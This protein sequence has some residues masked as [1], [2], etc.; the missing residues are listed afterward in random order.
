MA[1]YKK[2]KGFAVQT[3]SSDTAA[4]GVS[5]GAWASGGALN[6]ARGWGGRSGAGTQTAAQAAAGYNPAKSAN[7]E[8][9]N[10]SSWTET[11]DVNTARSS[12]SHG[13]IQTSSMVVGG[14]LAPGNS[15][16]TETWNGSAWTEVNN[17]NTARR[18][19]GMSTAGNSTSSIYFAGYSTTYVGIAESWNGSSWTEVGD[20]NTPRSSL[21]STDKSS[22]AA[23]GIAGYRGPP[24]ADR[25][26]FVEEWNGS[27][28]T[29]I[30]DVNQERMDLG[31]GGS[32]T[33]CI[34]FGGTDTT[35]LAVTESWDGSSWTE[36]AD[37]ATAR[38]EVGGTGS[39]TAGLV[40]GGTTPPYTSATEEF[41]ATTDFTKQNLGQVYFNST[42][43]TFKTTQSD[44]SGGTWASGGT[45]NSARTNISGMFAGNKT[46]A[47][48]YGGREAPPAKVAYTESYDG[49]SWTE[50]ND[51]N[52]ARHFAGGAGTQTA[53]LCIGNST[54]PQTVVE[55]WNGSSW[56]EITEINT[57]RG[58]WTCAGT[59]TDAIAANG[60]TNTMVN[61]NELWNGSTWT[62]SGNTNSTADGRSS[63]GNTSAALQAGGYITTSPPTNTTNTELWNGSSW[64]EVNN[65]NQAERAAQGGG[66]STQALACG[67]NADIPPFPAGLQTPVSSTEFWNGTSWTEINDMSTTRTE[68]GG[69]GN[70]TNNMVAGG[71]V[72]NAASYTGTS[73]EWTAALTNK[74]ITVS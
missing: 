56:T 6:N 8:N 51:L 1:E 23:L 47:L 21:T 64:T 53:A 11:T 34:I 67:G 71:Q 43:N 63:A 40:F 20:L 18:Q 50:V 59:Q 39:S 7:V 22:T 58:Y 14:W 24:T 55:S 45:M 19:A 31:C 52:T 3:L 30:A 35:Q 62:E 28:W 5:G 9:Y 44:I 66:S 49:S 54:A 16:S 29:E 4:S 32:Y 12:A 68:H 60:Y 72:T 26:K 48:I 69:R 33:D 41:T 61:S 17:L 38:T 27:A 10:G 46:A 2:E 73:E 74:T 25:T 42:T 57:G 36:I 15:D 37:M 13:G 65:L 70:G